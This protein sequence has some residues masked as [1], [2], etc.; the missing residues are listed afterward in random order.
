VSE[1]DTSD[2]TERTADG[3]ADDTEPKVDVALLA[4][5]VYRLMREQL[6]LDAARDARTTRF[7][8]A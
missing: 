7:G 8:G 5:K 1:S 2:T 4:E 3:S 6:R